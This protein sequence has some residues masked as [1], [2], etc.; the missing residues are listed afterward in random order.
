MIITLSGFEGCGKST[1]VENL[2]KN[3]GFIVI[4]ET[5]RLLI[6]LENTVFN[7]S[8]DDL[9]YKSFIAYLSSSHFIFENNLDETNKIVFDRNIIDSLTYLELYGNQKIDLYLLQDYI[10]TFLEEKNKNN[11]YTNVVLVEHSK[12]KDHIEKNIM[13]DS[14]RL[15]SDTANAYIEKAKEW[16]DIYMEKYTKLKNISMKFKKV[17]AFPENKFIFNDIKKIIN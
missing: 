8:R 13:K 15:Y 2:K 6:P 4:P 11:L 12:D 10:D 9:S 1:I 17:R 16:E 3:E 7:E 5:A 14:V